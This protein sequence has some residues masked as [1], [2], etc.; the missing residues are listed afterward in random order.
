MRILVAVLVAFTVLVTPGLADTYTGT[1]SDTKHFHNGGIAVDLDGEYPNEKMALYVAPADA[2]TIGP[3]P[4]VGAR[5]TASGTIKP[6]RGKP[7]IK[8]HKAGQW[9]W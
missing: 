7:E 8:I 1:V 3:I 6:Y 9:K 2:A 5:V 4:T